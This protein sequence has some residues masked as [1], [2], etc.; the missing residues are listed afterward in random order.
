MPCLLACR[1]PLTLTFLKTQ[2]HTEI[3]LFFSVSNVL[4]ACQLKV[5]VDCDWSSMSASYQRAGGTPLRVKLRVWK[6]SDTKLE[7]TRSLN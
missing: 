6:I 7:T 3:L 1:T 2:R 4:Y 5:N